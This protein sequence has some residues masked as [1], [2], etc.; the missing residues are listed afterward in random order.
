MDFH[1]LVI[2]RGL[3]HLPIAL[4][5]QNASIA[6]DFCSKTYYLFHFDPD[7][8]P[9]QDPLDKLNTN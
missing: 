4:F 6:I 7:Q 8:A 1:D 9:M 2:D 3:L 5:L